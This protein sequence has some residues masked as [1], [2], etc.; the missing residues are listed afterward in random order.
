M[1]KNGVTLAGIEGFG[2]VFDCGSC[3][4]IHLQVG[5]M[6]MTLDPSAYMKLV[7]MV[8][9]SAAN[10]ELW[11]AGGFGQDETEDTTENI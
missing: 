5:P 4:N 11:L 6:T 7:D 8:S 2:Q 9:T 1:Q 10:F 3:G